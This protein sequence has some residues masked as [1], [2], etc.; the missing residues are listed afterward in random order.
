RGR[1]NRRLSWEGGVVRVEVLST[2]GEW[3]GMRQDP[4]AVLWAAVRVAQQT[5][6]DLHLEFA[7]D[8]R[9]VAEQ[10]VNRLTN[11]AFSGVFYGNH[12]DPVVFVF[13]SLEHGRL[14][15]LG[16][17]LGFVSKDEPR[18][19]MGVGVLGSEIRNAHAA[20]YAMISVRAWSF[21]A[22]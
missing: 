9:R 17:V 8:E 11:D 10:T 14:G 16:D 7:A 13:N 15:Q 1:R 5:V 18:G 6:D 21:M 19:R 22:R 20:S 3:L 2:L 12:T 4:L